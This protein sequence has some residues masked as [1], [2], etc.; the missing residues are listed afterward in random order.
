MKN[1]K[2]TTTKYQIVTF[3]SW[4]VIE[5]NFPTWQKAYERMLMIDYG[6]YENEGGLTV[7]PYTA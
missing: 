4:R 2:A 6:Q 3:D 1:T 5:R 7:R